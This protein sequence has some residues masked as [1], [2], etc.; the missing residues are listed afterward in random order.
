MPAR[1]VSK[2]PLV[3]AVERAL[4]QNG[5]VERGSV[6]VAGVSGGADSVFLL[7]SLHALAAPFRLTL[8]VAHLDHGWRGRAAAADAAFVQSLGERLGVPVH[9]GRVDAPALARAERLS[10]EEAARTLRYRFFAQVCR[11]VGANV[12]ATG[13]TQDDQVETVLLAW[14]RGSGLAGLAGMEE[15]T[16][17]PGAPEITLIR[18]LLAISREA[19]RQALGELGYQ[20]RED[21]TNLDVRLLRNRVRLQVMPF[22]EHLFPSFRATTLRTARLAG[23]AYAFVRQAAA[24]RAA[25]LFVR[26]GERLRAP[27][28]AFLGLPAA[29]RGE[30]IR[31]AGA[32]LQG[33]VRDLEWAHVD[34]ALRAIE[35][36]RGGATVRLTRQLQVRLER[37]TIVVERAAQ[38]GGARPRGAE[39]PTLNSCGT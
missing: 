21:A 24:E 4:R 14:L 2:H 39:A 31:W 8:H 17:L 23:Q 38:P 32:Q 16:A 3:R 7:V 20:W 6:V 25:S 27:R 19:I 5:L 9:L 37:G 26:D 22:L 28:P 29:L 33:D 10:P 11:Q 18:P 13:H 1:P 36:G 12:V 15:R 30:A 34:G 35:R